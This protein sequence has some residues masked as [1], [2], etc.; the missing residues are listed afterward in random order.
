MTPVESVAYVAAG[1]VPTLVALELAW[2]M[3]KHIG[4]RGD[5]CENPGRTALATRS[6]VISL[7]SPHHHYLSR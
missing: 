7:P 6:R 2:R 3:G 1:F 5:P 4:K